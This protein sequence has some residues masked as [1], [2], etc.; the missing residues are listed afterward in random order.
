MIPWTGKL[1]AYQKWHKPCQR[2]GLSVATDKMSNPG[3]AKFMAYVKTAHT[4]KSVCRSLE[5]RNISGPHK[6]H[7]IIR[8]FMPRLHSADA[9]AARDSSIRRGRS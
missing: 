3:G 4:M 6:V 5:E 9:M 1:S 7:T 8:S 2:Q